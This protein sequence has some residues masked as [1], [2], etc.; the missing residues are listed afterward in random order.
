M[1]PAIIVLLTML[2]LMGIYI[3][4]ALIFAIQQALTH[5]L[6]NSRRTVLLRVFLIFPLWLLFTALTIPLIIVGVVCG[7]ILV[8]DFKHWW[9]K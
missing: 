7:V 9:K 3:V 6:G 2:S 5:E 1:H 8:N 4:I